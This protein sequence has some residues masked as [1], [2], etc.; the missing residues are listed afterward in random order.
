MKQEELL[1]RNTTRQQRQKIV[2]DSLGV[3]DGQCDGCMARIIDMYDDYI[4]GK[5]ELAEVN[6]SFSARYVRDVESLGPA[7][8]GRGLFCP[9]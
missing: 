4:D 5:K 3:I 7:P 9:E 8:R 1:I 2:E 6:A